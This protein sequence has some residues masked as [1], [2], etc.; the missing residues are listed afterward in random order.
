MSRIAREAGRYGDAFATARKALQAA[1]T[2]SERDAANSALC[3]AV[4]DEAAAAIA[5]A[6]QP[7]AIRLHEA[8]RI[9]S[10]TLL[11]EPGEHQ[12]SKALLGI[13]LLQGDGP[14]ALFAWRNYFHLRNG[15][16][17][18]GMLEEP[19]KNLNA[20]L[21]AWK[22]SSLTR[23]DRIRLVLALAGSRFFQYAALVARG[24]P[25]EETPA[26][27]DILAYADFLEQVRRV[28]EDYYRGIALGRSEES[29]YKQSLESAFGSLWRRLHCLR[30]Y[31]PYNRAQFLEEIR[32][33]FGAEVRL[34]ANG[35]FSGFDLIMGHRVGLEKKSVEQYGR[36]I[37]VRL[38]W[39][40]MMVENGYS[41][42]FW[43]GRATPGGW[44]AFPEIAWIRE[45]YVGEPYHNWRQLT[46]ARER[47]E[48]EREIARLSAGD[49]RLARANPYAYLPGMT[50]RA[51]F[52]QVRRLYDSLRAQ[53]YV[54][55]DLCLAFVSEFLRIKTESSIFA[56]EG[57]H[58]IDQA[59]F[60]W[61]SHL[62]SAAETEF[63]AKL[64][65]VAFAP[66]PKFALVGILSD[67][68]VAGRSAHSI[69]NLR[70][71]TI[72]LNWME[73]HSREIQGLDRSRPL[74][75]QLDLMTNEHI[76][77]ACREADS[78]AQ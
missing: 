35:N 34:G 46:D 37:E 50:G 70:M 77:Q 9:L 19:Y 47:S 3:R 31:P 51:H 6:R 60:P 14:T 48:R 61:R 68:N 54:G 57:R 49:D 58:A 23:E 65:E 39:I 27:Q 11:E 45:A 28:T 33:R 73:Q 18:S 8:R 29:G 36:R 42:W 4:L 52:A 13:S 16:A 15:Q 7:D 76:V 55:T 21:P 53:G 71:K 75:P 67:R 24:A 74:L 59:F 69:A 5:N 40:D 2:E 26:V 12:T 32:D 72:L 41:G 64:S 66:D 25:V 17:A 78:M 43:D 63:R 22:R 44:G 56:H 62:W 30:G 38:L 1:E 20:V 10:A